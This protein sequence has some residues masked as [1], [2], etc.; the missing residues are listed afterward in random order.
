LRLIQA[1]HGRCP[2]CGDFLLHAGQEPQSPPEW[3]LWL[4]AT[5]KALSKS[6]ITAEPGQG[7]PDESVPI[8]LIHAYCQRRHAAAVR[9]PELPSASTPKGLA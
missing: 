3:E 8:R 1:Q 7:A 5:R 4:K 9:S 6:A 2:L